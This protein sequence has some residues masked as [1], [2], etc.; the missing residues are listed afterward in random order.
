MSAY[1]LDGYDDILTALDKGAVF[2]DFFKLW[3]LQRAHPELRLYEVDDEVRGRYLFRPPLVYVPG[4]VENE[5][6]R[7]NAALARA[8]GSATDE[9]LRGG[10]DEAGYPF[11]A[12]Q[13]AY[14]YAGSAKTPRNAF[15]TYSE[16]T[17]LSFGAPAQAETAA[18]YWPDLDEADGTLARVLGSG[19]LTVALGPGALAT[20]SPAAF[21]LAW[22]D[23]EGF[24][25]WVLQGVLLCLSRKAGRLV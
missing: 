23:P 25:D 4:R 17:E 11:W 10:W 20:R 19:V 12:L 15:R 22:S 7:G 3:R 6:E 2:A 13:K 14:F 18:A 16:Q 8:L 24:E 21:D 9:L 1:P 5:T